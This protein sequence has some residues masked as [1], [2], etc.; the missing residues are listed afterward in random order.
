MGSMP[1]G[2]TSSCKGQNENSKGDEMAIE[3]LDEEIII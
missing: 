2:A 3:N 1:T